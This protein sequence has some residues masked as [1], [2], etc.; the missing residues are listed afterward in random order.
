GLVPYLD[1]PRR[2]EPF[3]HTVEDLLDPALL[4]EL[5]ADTAEGRGTDDPVVLASLWWQSYAYRTAGALLAAW[6]LA[7]SAPDPAISTGIGIRI[8]RARPAKLVLGEQAEEITDPDRLVD[9][10][11]TDNLDRM[12]E[13]LRAGHR[14]GRRLIDGNTMASIATGFSTVT[15]AEGGPD[16]LGAGIEAISARLPDRLSGLIRWI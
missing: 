10:L 6:V 16:D 1:A 12:A 13:S 15:T 5:V 8:A 11:F 4:A 3:D 9:R 7:G 14:I 2:P